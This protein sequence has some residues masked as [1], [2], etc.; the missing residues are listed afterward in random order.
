[1]ILVF[2]TETTGTIDKGATFK[3]LSGFPNLVQ[4]AWNIYTNEGKLISSQSY[5]I[6]PIGFTNPKT[7]SDI[8]GITTEDAIKDGV[9]SKRIMQLFNKDVN[10]ATVLVAHNFRFDSKI[11]MAE[12]IR[13]GDYCPIFDKKKE[14]FDTM[15][16]YKNLSK[17]KFKNGAKKF[18]KLR[19]LYYTIF[20]KYFE[21]EH[22]ALADVEACA[23]IYFKLKSNI[24]KY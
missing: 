6:K 15:V 3:P 2:D 19:D 5:I 11:V 18:P 23:D 8:H 16:K 10:K 20:N 9:D 14:V 12:S 1:M 4:I 17:N 21:N 22:N 24:W 13:V 7:A